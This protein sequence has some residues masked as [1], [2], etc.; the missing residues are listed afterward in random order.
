M[1]IRG[2]IVLVSSTLGLMGIVGYSQY[3]PTKHALKGLAECLRQ[4]LM[5]FGIK[6]HIYYVATI[7]SP[8]NA[9]ENLTKPQITK[10][11]EEGD[12]SDASPQN[13]AKCLLGGIDREQFAISSDILTDLFRCT[14]GGISPRNSILCDP[15]LAILGAIA[16]PLWRHYADYLVQRTYDKHK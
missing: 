12:I 9:T 8:G 16:I 15:L 5:P 14:P 3:S 6:V 2:R 11:I 10:M 13:R 4:E 7:D 1:N